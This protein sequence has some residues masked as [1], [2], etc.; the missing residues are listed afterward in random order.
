VAKARGGELAAEARRQL[1]VLN[2]LAT[3]SDNARN[4][5]ERLK[6]LNEY[7]TQSD[8]FITNN[9]NVISI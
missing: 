5:G 1:E 3:D 6:L 8:A 4:E 7:L 2:R 9:P